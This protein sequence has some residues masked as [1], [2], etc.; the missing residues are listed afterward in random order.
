M[1]KATRVLSTPRRTASSRKRQQPED[2][3][4]ASAAA[5]HKPARRKAVAS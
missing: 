4:P 5:A 3:E 1:A 2:A